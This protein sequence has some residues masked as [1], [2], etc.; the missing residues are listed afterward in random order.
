MNIWSIDTT[1][2]SHLTSI[3]DQAPKCTLLLKYL[4]CVRTATLAIVSACLCSL[5]IGLNLSNQECSV[6]WSSEVESSE[7]R[8]RIVSEAA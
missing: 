3:N 7:V 2:A 6:G 5:I 8:V 1:A 4:D